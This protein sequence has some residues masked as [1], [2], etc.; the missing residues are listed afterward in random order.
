MKLFLVGHMASGKTTV[1][2]KLSLLLDLRWVDTDQWIEGRM[3]KAIPEIFSMHGESVFRQ[4]EEECLDFLINQD[5]LVISCGGGMPCYDRT[6]D[7]MNELGE[8]IYLRTPIDTLASRLWLNK[9]NRPKI[10]FF[11]D[12]NT[13]REF[14]ST[15][16]I[17]R[18]KYYMQSK[19]IIETKGKSVFEVSNEIKILF[20]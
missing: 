6:I 3:C 20:R 9:N 19:Y 2:E 18:E 13:L 4:K 10:P 12:E 1:G 16:L 8:T 15:E 5:N 14:V 11:N 7:L 17:N